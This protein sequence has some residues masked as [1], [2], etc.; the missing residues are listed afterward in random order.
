MRE[1]AFDAMADVFDAAKRS[2]I[3]SRIKGRGNVATEVRLIALFRR[4][5]ITGWRRGYPVFGKPD[6]VFLRARVAVFVDG[7]FWHGHPTRGKVPATNREFWLAKIA[8]N[9]MRDKLVNHTL[10]AKAWRVIRIWQS[11]LC[12]TR[13]ARKLR[14]LAALVSEIPSKTVAARYQNHAG[15]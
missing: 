4:Y 7:D 9:K 5:G 6:F 13:G 15:S 12:N 11:D 3:M 2:E 8:R 10:R 14:R 1:S